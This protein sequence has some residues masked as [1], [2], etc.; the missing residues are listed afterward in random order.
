MP[1]LLCIT[2]T[3]EIK[4]V[5]CDY[6]CEDLYKKANFKSSAGFECKHILTA[7]D[8]HIAVYGKTSGKAGQE[9]KYEFPPPIDNL[10]FFGSC[11]LLKCESSKDPTFA[12][13]LTKANWEKFY[14]MCMEGF[15]DIDSEFDSEEEE[16]ED[17]DEYKTTFSG[18]QDDGFVVDDEEEEV[19]PKRQKK[20]D[21]DEE[22]DEEN[23]V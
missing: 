2:K 15:E 7:G 5:K 16:T 21:I 3:G 18:Y 10:L 12:A 6:N 17:E 9:N 14:D 23:Y 13:S 4:E 22:L 19:K 11:L 20:K 1:T 8:E